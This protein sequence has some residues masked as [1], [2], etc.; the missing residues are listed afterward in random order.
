MKYTIETFDWKYYIDEHSDLKQANINSKFKAWYH[1]YHFGRKESRKHRSV[2]H[3]KIKDKTLK[4]VISST[5]YAGYGGAAT[6]VYQLIKLFR[7][8]GYRVAGLFL[9]HIKNKDDS[10]L[11]P[12]NIGNI[13]GY[14]YDDEYEQKIDPNITVNSIIRYLD[15]KPDICLA[16]NYVAPIFTKQFFNCY[17]CY[18]VSGINH[19]RLFFPKITGL[20]VLNN[21]FMIKNEWVIDKEVESNTKCDKIICN[22]QI[23]RNIFKK[24]YPNFINKIGNVVDTTS[25]YKSVTIKDCYKKYD[26]VVVCSNLTR[27]CKNNLF[28]IDILRHSSLARYSK[29]IIGKNNRKFKNIPNSE[30]PGLLSHTQTVEMMSKAKILLFPSF[31]DSNSNTVREAYNHKCLPLISKNIGFC[32]LFPEELVCKSFNKYEWYIKLLHLLQNYENILHKTNINFTKTISIE[33]FL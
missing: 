7:N 10:K 31:F 14:Y 12:D 26:I 8:Q 9:N 30:C 27:K 13:F 21:D 17:I 18:L 24:I 1:W 3:Q 15:G 25:A 2:F 5:Q 20:E 6:N 28:L 22:S 23:T 29:I 11:D 19:F 16:K 32:E 33:D 4:I